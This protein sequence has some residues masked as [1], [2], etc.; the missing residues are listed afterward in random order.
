MGGGVYVGQFSEVMKDRQ[1]LLEWGTPLSGTECKHR[2]CYKERTNRCY[3]PLV[4]SCWPRYE[5]AT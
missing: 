3:K 4:K 1:W 2:G 5:A